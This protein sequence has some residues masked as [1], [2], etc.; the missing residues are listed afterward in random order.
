M[1]VAIIDRSPERSFAV[2]SLRGF[3]I[4]TINERKHY[5]ATDNRGRA[6]VGPVARR[7]RPLFAR[8]VSAPALVLMASED[9]RPASLA[10]VG[11]NI[12]RRLGLPTPPPPQKRS[13]WQ[14]VK[15]STVGKF[16][17]QDW[18]KAVQHA[19]VDVISWALA[20]VVVSF[21]VKAVLW[22]WL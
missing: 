10:D 3:R 1:T 18:H 16:Y 21:V 2:A 6:V 12:G 5:V 7:R 19:A 8:K 20:I 11:A 14:R 9:D 15:D 13:L 17:D 22:T 4:D